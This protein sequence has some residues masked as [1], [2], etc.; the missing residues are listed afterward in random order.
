[1]KESCHCTQILKRCLPNIGSQTLNALNH[2]CLKVCH[3]RNVCSAVKHNTNMFVPC[4]AN[5]KQCTCVNVLN[6]TFVEKAVELW[7]S[8]LRDLHTSIWTKEEG[9]VSIIDVI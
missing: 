7:I 8:I 3:N 4:L 9:I 6:I 5:V 2:R 1:M